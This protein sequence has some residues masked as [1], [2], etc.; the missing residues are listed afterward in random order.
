MLKTRKCNHN[1]LYIFIFCSIAA[2]IG[3]EQ[4]NSQSNSDNKKDKTVSANQNIDPDN[5]SDKIVLS[6]A[7]WK[8]K[9][10]PEQYYVCREKGTE[11]AFTGSLYNNKEKGTYNCIAC[12]HPLFD[13]D[14][15]FD[16]GTG[17]PS[18]W[19][20]VND[21]NVKT[22]IDRIF[23]M[24]RIEVMCGRCDSHLGHVFNDGPAPTNKRYC[25]N[26]VSLAFE[27]DEK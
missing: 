23:G 10:T 15:K 12:G 18:F 27:K 16:S 6:E 13:S 1:I 4:V 8:K 20:P 11:R 7:D 21:K 5:K 9:L 24:Q 26:S 19:D 25:I 17:W 14:T 22:E 2:F 3:C